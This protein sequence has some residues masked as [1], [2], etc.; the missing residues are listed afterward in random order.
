MLGVVPHHP[1]LPCPGPETQVSENLSS[2]AFFFFFLMFECFHNKANF[3]IF[4][5][6]RKVAKTVLR[7]PG[8][9][10]SPSFCACHHPV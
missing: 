7:I 2:D 1:S 4:Y 10:H 3:K 6:Y 8:H 5:I 9:P